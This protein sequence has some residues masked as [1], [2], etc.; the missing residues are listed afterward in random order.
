MKFEAV[1]G[2][3]AQ[4]DPLAV[5]Q[6]IGGVPPRFGLLDASGDRWASLLATLAQ[7]NA[8]TGDGAV[9]KLVFFGRHGQGYH[10]VAEDKYGTDAWD[11]HWAKL[12]GDGEL[13]WGPD[14]ELTSLGKE[15]ALAAKAMWKT[16][17]AQGL[18]LP[19]SLYCSPMTRAM[20]TQQITF[21]GVDGLKPALIMEDCREEYGEHTCDKRRS[22]TYIQENFP[23]FD[24]EEGFSE[25][26]ELY[27]AEDR[28]TPEHAAERA[29]RV[30]E[31]VFT[32]DAGR[33]VI[34]I[35]A[36]SGIINGFLRA[37]GRPRYALPTGGI[38]PVVVKATA[39]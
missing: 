21:E 38:L 5:P 8:T 37:L 12:D 14:P 4:D 39:L 28:E 34:S 1:G 30:L 6:K 16:E 3:F 29:R 7:L 27:T 20:Q 31:H 22:K 23:Q 35:T 13:V 26:D 10:N 19:E 36:H 11:D 32:A 15:Q 33:T 24:I 17:L 25:E 18:P 2:L 9:Y